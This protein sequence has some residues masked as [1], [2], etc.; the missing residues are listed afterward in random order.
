MYMPGVLFMDLVA[1]SGFSDMVE[2]SRAVWSYWS[3][4]RVD[5]VMA[6]QATSCVWR[7]NELSQVAWLVGFAASMVHALERYSQGE[8]GGE[9]WIRG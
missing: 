8:S 4:G 3:R 2:F 7:C 6:S 9:M 5:G 1:L